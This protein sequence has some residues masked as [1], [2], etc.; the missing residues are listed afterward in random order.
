LVIEKIIVSQTSPRVLIINCEPLNPKTATGL[1]MMSLFRGWP[2]EQL[3]QFYTHPVIPDSTACVNTKRISIRPINILSAGET[4]FSNQSDDNH[5]KWNRKPAIFKVSECSGIKA[6]F[7]YR[8]KDK[9]QARLKQ[10]AFLMPY[11]VSNVLLSWIKK[12]KPDLIY[13]MLYDIDIMSFVIKLS[14]LFKL[15][16]VPHFMDDWPTTLR[17]RNVFYRFL[18]P[19]LDLKLEEVLKR[20]PIGMVIGD[21]MS[22]EFEKRYHRDMIPF[23]HCIEPEVLEQQQRGSHYERK[24]VRFI[25]IG[26]LHLNRWKSLQEIGIAM[27]DLATEGV[28]AECLIYTHPNDVKKYEKVLTIPPVMKIEG[29]LDHDEV[30]RTQLGADC[31]I[32]VESFDSWDISFTQLSVSSKLPEYLASG[33]AIFAYGPREV[34][35]IKYINEIGCGFIVGKKDPQLLK[36]KIREAATFPDLRSK[37]GDSAIAAAKSRHDARKQREE[38]QKALL[39]ACKSKMLP[40][41]CKYEVKSVQ[42]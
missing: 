2:K 21:A 11:N 7:Q 34:A 12:F 10:L 31:L 29:S 27:S 30:H 42:G 9:V 13:S 8:N 24:T 35:S 36:Q 20:S 4:I 40:N 19:F 17:E 22:I 1:T 18:S 3:A 6:G 14:D 25:Y 15:P 32:H 26:G 5:N 39:R 28:K 38:F 37:L 23:M 33:R 16:I 41:K